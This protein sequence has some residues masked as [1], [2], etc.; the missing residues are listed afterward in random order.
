MNVK[1]VMFGQDHYVLLS[2]K[3]SN[4][5]VMLYSIAKSRLKIIIIAI[6]VAHHFKGLARVQ[7]V[8]HTLVRL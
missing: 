4:R 2:G 3:I 7:W 6:L 1:D 8:P 5:T